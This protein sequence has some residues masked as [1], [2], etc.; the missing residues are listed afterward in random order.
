M[1]EAFK[2]LYN[3]T[4]NES[5]LNDG[6]QTLL[7]GGNNKVIKSL[8]I[9]SPDIDL[10]GT[11]LELDGEKISNVDLKRGGTFNMEGHLIVPSTSTLKIKTSDWP[12]VASKV[13]GVSNDNDGYLHYYGYV[14][15]SAGNAISGITTPALVFDYQSHDT[16]GSLSYSAQIIDA[17]YLDTPTGGQNMYYIGHDDNSQQVYYY[18]RARPA[19]SST[20]T[21]ANVNQQFNYQ[22][23]RVFG[24][25]DYRRTWWT[26]NGV[27]GNSLWVEMRTNGQMV[28]HPIYTNPTTFSIGGLGGANW[29]NTSTGHPSPYPTSS[30]PRGQVYNAMYC[31]IPSSGYSTMY[32]KNL[33]NGSFHEFVMNHQPQ[34]GHGDFCLSVDHQADE[35]YIYMYTSYTQITQFK[36]PFSW[37]D[38]RTSSGAAS[39]PSQTRNNHT[40][41]DWAEVN[42]LTVPYMISDFQASQFGTTPQGGVRFRIQNGDMVTMDKNGNELYR[43]SSD[44]QFGRSASTANVWRHFGHPITSSDAQ[45][46]G[47]DEADLKITITGIEQT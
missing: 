45:T 42:Q 16:I 3:A 39:S 6:E 11:Y 12:R 14:E 21:G 13:I 31:Y 22:N 38:M 2:R 37:T 18:T 7:T 28:A 26:S 19:T 24:L 33:L 29:G 15:D 20:T 9:T 35:W 47:L 46:Y 32:I 44:P 8:S 10:T 17:M 27:P 34:Y 25:H 40:Y 1:A 4:L 43:H 36:A 30:Y 5:H 41:A 23:Y